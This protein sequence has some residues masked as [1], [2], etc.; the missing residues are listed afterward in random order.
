MTTID[1]INTEDI[2]FRIIDNTR[3]VLIAPAMPS[4]Q[5]EGVEKKE[6]NEESKAK[7]GD[8]LNLI[9]VFAPSAQ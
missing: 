3:P 4:S 2:L 5:E 6:N 7:R 1:N 9:S 8:L